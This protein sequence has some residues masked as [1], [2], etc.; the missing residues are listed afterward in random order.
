M[1]HLWVDKTIKDKFIAIMPGTELTECID[2]VVEYCKEYNTSASL[3]FN[4]KT[5]RIESWINSSE[6]RDVWFQEI[7]N[8][9]YN[10]QH[11]KSRDRKI[12]VILR[13]DD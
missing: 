4:G 13:N 1:K 2:L 3:E 10:E 9:W 12:N 8:R 11:V 5:N 7:D 6:L